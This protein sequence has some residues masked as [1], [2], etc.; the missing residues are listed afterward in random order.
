MNWN[1]E[2]RAGTAGGTLL[3]AIVQLTTADLL[4][5]VVCAALGAIVSYVVTRLLKHLLN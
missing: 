1:Y 3:T 2:V 5:T 4:K